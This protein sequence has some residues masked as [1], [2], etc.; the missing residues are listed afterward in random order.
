MRSNWDYTDEDDQPLGEWETITCEERD[1]LVMVPS[2]GHPGRVEYRDTL[3]VFAGW[4][5]WTDS[6]KRYTEWGEKGSSVPLIYD[7]LGGEGQRCEH[8]RFRAR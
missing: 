5:D 6:R 3:T 7:Y 8:A 1:A 2:E 4:T